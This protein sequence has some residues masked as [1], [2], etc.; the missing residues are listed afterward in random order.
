MATSLRFAVV[1]L[2]LLT[3]VALGIIIVNITRPAHV[4]VQAEVPPPLQ[5]SY[6]VAA[7]PI[8]PGTLARDE[9][10]TARSAP[11]DHL[12]AG[13]ITDTPDAHASLRGSLVRNFID[14]GTPIT[15]ADV[16]RPRDR[17]FIASVLEPGMRAVTIGVDPVSGV[18]GLIW[19]GDHVDIILTQELDKAPIAHRAL[20]ETVLTNVR[21]IA[22]DQEIVQ[23][24]AADNTAAGKLARTVTLQVDPSQAEKIAVAVH[25]GKLALSIRSAV[26]RPSEQAATQTTTF[27]ADVSPA[28]SRADRPVGATVLVV[29]GDK[30]KEV[31]FQ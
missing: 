16:L 17:G 24:A 1:G 31:T 28:L 19:P 2:M 5:A 27:G 6:L 23:G 18:A 7:R 14:S 20:S 26:D 25:L 11:I 8:P 22:V 4:P 9:D 10:F 29:D 3:A 21:V 12:P 15:A 30:R 13:A